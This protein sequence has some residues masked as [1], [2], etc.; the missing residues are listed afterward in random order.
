MRSTK[1]TFQC[2]LCDLPFLTFNRLSYH[3]RVAHG[4]NQRNSSENV[5]LNAF[6]C[7]DPQFLNELRSVQHFLVH[8]KI[9]FG[10]KTVYIFRLTKYSPTFINEKLTEIFN[11]LNCAVKINLSLGFVLHDLVET[12]DYRYFYPANNIPLFQLPLTV[13][14]EDNLDKLKNKIEQRDAFNQCVSH[15]RN[16]NFSG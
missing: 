12:Q 8:S 1:P 14:N 9:E 3:K 2:T 15:R 5:D 11:E 16:G 7:S 10:K 13:A 6:Q 4:C